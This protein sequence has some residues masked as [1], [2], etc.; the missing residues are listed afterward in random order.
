MQEADDNS[1]ED[2]THEDSMIIV[3]DDR[4]TSN[5]DL[6][7]LETSSPAHASASTYTRKTKRQ[8]SDLCNDLPAD[9]PIKQKRTYNKR[10]RGG[11]GRGKK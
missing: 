3:N 5:D 10:G 1:N 2:V 7:N 4:S 6:G 11:R 8:L 9:E